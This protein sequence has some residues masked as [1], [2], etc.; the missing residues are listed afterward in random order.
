M[1]GRARPLDPRDC[2]G[3]WALPDGLTVSSWVDVAGTGITSLP[4]SPDDVRLRWRGVRVDAR[5][6]FLLETITAQEV[7]A[8]P[9]AER[10]RVMVERT[11]YERFFAG[12]KAR[13][14]D[15]DDDPGGE[16][17]LLKVAM[18]GDEDL[19]CLQVSCPSTGRRYVIRVPPG[20]RTCHAA[21]AWV[22]GFDDPDDYHPLADT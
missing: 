16:R 13:V 11:G 22:A 10:R 4:R 12:A 15:A 6:A 18:D 20:T 19:V 14:L 9:N 3:I 2:A 5:I 8:G 1:R 21:A 7:P 17:R